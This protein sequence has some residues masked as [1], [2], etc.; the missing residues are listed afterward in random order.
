MNSIDHHKQIIRTEQLAQRRANKQSEYD[1]A[2]KQIVQNLTKV[3]IN[4]NFNIFGLY[5]PMNGEP[6]IFK[7]F[8]ETGKIITLPKI[9]A[10]NIIFVEYQPGDLLEQSSFAELKQPQSTQQI[11]PEIIVMPGLAFSIKGDRLGF[12]YGNYDK[13]LYK[14]RKFC[15]PTVI[16]VCFHENLKLFLPINQYDQKMNYIVTDQMILKI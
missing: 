6:D 16:G 7:N 10:N 9:I 11:I 15:Q 5:L 12:G 1:R 14:I 8:V 2:N 4:N 3:L 13:Y